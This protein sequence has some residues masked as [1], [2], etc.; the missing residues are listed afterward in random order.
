MTHEKPWGYTVLA[1]AAAILAACASGESALSSG[2]A[3][4]TGADSLDSAITICAGETERLL[5]P[6]LRTAVVGFRA[7]SPEVS[8][9]IMEEYM[10]RFITGRKVVVADRQNMDLIKRELRFTMSDYAD[11]ATAL[12]AGKMLGVQ[13]VVIGSLED[14]GKTL[15]LEVQAFNTQS[16]EQIAHASAD[17]IRDE[18][19]METLAGIE[20]SR[21]KAKPLKDYL[22]EAE[23]GS[24]E[25][26][27]PDQAEQYFI[28][29]LR[30]RNSEDYD[31]AIAE[32]TKAIEINPVMGVAYHMRALA[33]Y[34]KGDT[35][36][37]IENFSF[38]VSF[39]PSLWWAYLNRGYMHEKRQENNKALA[40]YNSAISL[41]A[42]GSEAYNNRGN[43]YSAAGEYDKAIADYNKAID[44]EL[45]PGYLFYKEK[46][47]L[48]TV[49][50]N[51][52]RAYEATYDYEQAIADYTESIK[53][54]PDNAQTYNE[55]GACYNVMGDWNK[56][57]ADFTE[58]VRLEPHNPDYARNVEVMRRKLGIK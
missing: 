29:G 3:A 8:T 50:M 35:A 25:L 42:R 5:E 48:N 47:V 38:V 24:I 36:A 4:S 46:N 12:D 34:D 54:A 31:L 56:A 41:N 52:G 18:R 2:S 28:N 14:D 16:S 40:D 23:K 21:I 57:L 43:I 53:W 39:A 32:F 15:R 17:I 22:A 9:Y 51:R 20:S 27:E 6:G 45:K 26:P 37:A 49:F 30:Y 58:A 7:R 44:V 55:R 33:Y 1:L 19:V 10:G 11:P 13:A